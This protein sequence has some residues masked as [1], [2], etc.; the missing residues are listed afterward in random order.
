MLICRNAQGV[1]GHRKVGNP[2]LEEGWLAKMEYTAVVCTCTSTMLFRLRV[3]ATCA[4]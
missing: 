2:D 4:R 3:S 1:H